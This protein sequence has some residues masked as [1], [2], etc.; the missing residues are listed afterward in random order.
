MGVI[1]DRATAFLEEVRRA[2]EESREEAGMAENA[3]ETAAVLSGVLEAVEGGVAAVRDSGLANTLNEMTARTVVRTVNI[4]V[5]TD[6][7]L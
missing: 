5:V 1:D 6:I 4:I 2:V 7:K 3:E